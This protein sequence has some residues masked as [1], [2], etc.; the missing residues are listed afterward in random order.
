[1]IVKNARVFTIKRYLHDTKL[2]SVEPTQKIKTEY[3]GEISPRKHNHDMAKY[4]PEE[5][6]SKIESKEEYDDEHSWYDRED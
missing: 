5:I 6:R 4:T 1:M 3:I 2:P